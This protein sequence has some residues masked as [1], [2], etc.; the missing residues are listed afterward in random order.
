MLPDSNVYAVRWSEQEL[1]G[2]SGLSEALVQY[3]WSPA[4]SSCIVVVRIAHIHPGHSRLLSVV[5]ALY[6]AHSVL[7]FVDQ[8]DGDS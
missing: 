4:V 6:T 8:D 5:C 2:R 7:I 1:L 3:V